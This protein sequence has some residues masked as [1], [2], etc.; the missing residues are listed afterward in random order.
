MDRN[1][2]I[3]RIKTALEHRSGK[4]WSVTGGRGTAYGWITIAAPPARC[5]WH[6]RPKVAGDTT[7]G[8]DHWEEY[9]SGERGGYMGPADREA[10]AKLLSLERMHNQGESIPSSNAYYQEFLDRAEGRRPS[11]V[12]TPYWD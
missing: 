1:E 8:T 5:T 2:T 3:R 10:L 4:R 12:G 6:H 11:V 7:P 9:D